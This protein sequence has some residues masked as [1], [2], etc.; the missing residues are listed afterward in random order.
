MCHLFIGNPTYL[1]VGHRTWL[2][3]LILT[4]VQVIALVLLI[5]L[6]RKMTKKL[7][8][9]IVNHTEEDMVELL[10]EDESRE[11]EESKV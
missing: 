11:E 7:P 6:Y 8:T 1:I 3:M 10:T 2:T 4:G 5:V 9:V